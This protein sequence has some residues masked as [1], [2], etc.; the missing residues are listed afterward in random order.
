MSIDVQKSRELI[1]KYFPNPLR[2]VMIE[3]Y[4]ETIEKSV[5]LLNERM[6]LIDDNDSLNKFLDEIINGEVFY[7]IVQP[8]KVLFYENRKKYDYSFIANKLVVTPESDTP[9]VEREMMTVKLNAPTYLSIQDTL[10]LKRILTV[11]KFIY[12]FTNETLHTL[13]PEFKLMCD[14]ID[15]MLELDRIL[16]I[17]YRSDCSS[18]FVHI[19]D[20]FLE[21]FRIIEGNA[22]KNILGVFM[23][24]N[25]GI[26]KTV[27]KNIY[28]SE[29]VNSSGLIDGNVS[30]I[31]ENDR[32]N[33]PDLTTN[34]RVDLWK[35]ILHIGLFSMISYFSVHY[36][37]SM[38]K[39]NRK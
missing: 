36:Y 6:S 35:S 7:D 37:D 31:E 33:E 25:V 13:C 20:D 30:A 2:V 14:Y 22:S 34:G 32:L 18:Y 11:V 24:N 15:E 28:S 5:P 39:K 10:D 26:A 3:P 27:L 1:I 9:T 12:I 8:I 19:F 23:M 17:K 21:D 38:I 4:L 29:I 16:Q